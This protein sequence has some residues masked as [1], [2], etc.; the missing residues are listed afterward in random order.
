MRVLP[1]TWGWQ[2]DVQEPLGALS[3]APAA[4]QL[5]ASAQILCGPVCQNPTLPQDADLV[6]PSLHQREVMSGGKHHAPRHAP[7]VDCASGIH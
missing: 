6:H 5:C 7:L 1:Q 4:G 3:A 2:N